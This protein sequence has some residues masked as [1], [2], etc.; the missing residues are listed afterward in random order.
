MWESLRTVRKYLLRYRKGLAI[1]GL[2][3]VLKDVSQALQPL[4][5]RS[6]VDHFPDGGF[7]RFA[8]YLVGL[9][10]LKGV[11][12]YGM[13]V[14][15][16]G[17]SR[18]IEFDLRNDLYAHLIRL[19][20]EYYGRT[21]TGDIMARA[22]ND[23]NAVRMMLGP[24][25]MY[26]FETSLTFLL[27]IAIMVKVDWRLA[28]FA[29]MPA[30]AVSF[31]VVFFGRRIHDRFEK[32]QGMFSDISSRVQENLSG[33]R[34]VRAFVQEKAE[35]RRFE[36]LNKQYIAQSLKLVRIQGIF[37]PLLE[38]LIGLTFLAVLWIGGQQV[39]LGRISVGSFVMFNTYMGMLVWP[40]IAFGWVVNLTQR[41]SASLRRINEILREQPSIAAPPDA[42]PLTDVKGE[43]EFRGATVDYGSGPVVNG[44]D[45]RIP[46]GT[47]LAI[48]G[49]TGSGKS[50]LVNLI[51]RLLDP[52]GGA[53]LVDGIDVRRLDPA[54]LRRHIGFVP[55]ETFLFSS[56]IGANIAFGVDNAT[57]EQIR[58]AAE[59]AG[60][61]E[62]IESFPAGYQTIVGERGITLSGGQKQ[63]TAIA[64]ALLRDPRILILD[65]AL[66]SVD[67]LTEE[68][69]LTH[70]A[71]VMRGR[72][73]ILISHRVSTVQQADRIV[74]L[75]KG[76]IVEQGSHAELLAAGGYYAGLSQKQTL[77]EELEVAE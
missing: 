42:V 14:I 61:A 48:V 71:G 56:T 17:I 45:L 74:V 50:T 28:I 9:A 39:L 72:T 35:M 64:R 13:R 21:R 75:E 8:G 70:L 18:D 2:C 66:S 76:R 15:L 24:G 51:P 33:V 23:L 77:E 41:G 62:D 5:I 59:L 58:R 55:Q 25:V 16:I 57:E 68:R 10:L 47:T 12:Q 63:R 44:V 60:L 65:D 67:T 27:A 43:I 22:T 11:F 3:L 26:W 54:A 38:A 52:T 30:P 34:M 29:V 31:A 49:H 73:V 19:A 1:G 46:A 6:A 7:L 53:I 20:P 4:M 40:M 69:I 32:L 37:D 36:E